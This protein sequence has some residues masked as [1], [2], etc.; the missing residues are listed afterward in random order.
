MVLDMGLPRLGGHDV[1]REFRAHVE[2][3]SIPIVV[4]TGSATDID[5]REFSCV[6]RKPLTP[7]ALADAVARSL[8]ERRT[9][10]R[11]F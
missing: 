3:R 11:T 6:L 7:Q 2:T 10:Q 8:H 9:Y 5:E 4:V 1:A